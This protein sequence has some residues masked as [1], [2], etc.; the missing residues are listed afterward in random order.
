MTQGHVDNRNSEGDTVWAY[1][2]WLFC[3]A[4]QPSIVYIVN[5]LMWFV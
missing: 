3:S 1:S 5:A 4:S 2:L